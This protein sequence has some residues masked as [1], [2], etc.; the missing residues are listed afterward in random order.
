MVLNYWWKPPFFRPKPK[1]CHLADLSHIDVG[2]SGTTVNDE[3]VL[4]IHIHREEGRPFSIGF[5]RDV[6][7]LE[8]LADI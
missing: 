7:N 3:P 1:E 4:V 6:E 2:P 8:S 5:G